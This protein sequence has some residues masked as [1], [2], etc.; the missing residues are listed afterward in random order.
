ML[1][2]L[3]FWLLGLAGFRRHVLLPATIKTSVVK[4]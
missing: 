2:R 3:W 4:E 1:R